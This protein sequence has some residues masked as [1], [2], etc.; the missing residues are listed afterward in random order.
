MCTQRVLKEVQRLTHEADPALVMR[1]EADALRDMTLGFSRRAVMT[2][3]RF[4]SM[5][6]HELDISVDRVA[7]SH[8]HRGGCAC[9]TPSRARFKH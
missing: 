8:A 5:E 7:G 2:T 4:A 9:L 6:P 3:A 1:A